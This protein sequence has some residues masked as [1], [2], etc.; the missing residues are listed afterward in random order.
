MQNEKTR[1]Q[2]SVTIDFSATGVAFIRLA[3]D[4]QEVVILN[5]QRLLELKAILEQFK[6]QQPKALVIIASGSDMFSVGADIK[7]IGKVTDP[8]D[9]A[10]LAR[11]GQEVF[12][13]I[14]ALS[15][16]TIAAISGPCVGG[17]CE[18]VLACKYRIITDRKSSIIGLPEIKL[19]I[20]PGFGG[21]QR[22]PRL[23]GLS[24]AADLILAGKLLKP[25]KAREAGLVD[26]VV[27]WE[28][29]RNR[30]E[31]I[32]LGRTKVKRS[33]GLKTQVLLSKL[34][35][36]RKIIAS[37]AESVVRA[38]TKGFYPAP[39]AAL[40]C[41]LFGYDNGMIAGLE[42]EAKQLGRLIAS[43]E[44]KALVNVFFLTE[45]AKSI[46][47][48]AAK[49][50]SNIKTMVIGAGVM[51]AGIATALA[52]AELPVV[53]RDTNKEALDRGL[54]HAKGILAKNKSLSEIQRNDILRKISTSQTYSEASNIGLVIEAVFEEMSVKQ[55]VFAEL[56]PH[57]SPDAL[58]ASNTSSLSISALAENIANPQRVVGMHFF[59]PVEKM[60]LVEIVRGQKTDD[61]TLVILAA[62]TS[63]LQKFPIIVEDVPGFLINRVLVPYLNE[64]A[65]LLQEGCSIED[66]D[67]SA[68]DFGLPMG[69]IRLLDEVGLDIAMHVQKSLSDAYG[70]RMFGPTFCQ[71]LVA[72][73]KKGRKNSSGFYL[74]KGKEELVDQSVYELLGLKRP[75]T[76][77]KDQ[78]KKIQSRLVHALLNEAIRC[79][80]EGVAGAPGR[81]AAQQ[82]DL[83]TVMGM[84]FPP[85]RGGVIFFADALGAAGVYRTL[86]ELEASCGKRF[87][88]TAGIRARAER[89]LSFY[90]T[91]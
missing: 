19:G 38:K 61:K 35:V 41:M 44:C 90:E 22:L 76:D 27:P 89:N 68:L 6:Q 26:Q 51:G 48:S 34:S 47:K 67:K 77:L 9:G 1:A 15:C 87:A 25:N 55:Q 29:L 23:I 33:F 11:T 49:T 17:G 31:E 75:A 36:V 59:N 60:P 65:F 83:G 63:K 84:G 7:V 88:P 56:A 16:P 69:P 91:I 82:I 28:L 58:V 10:K 42:N 57:L 86:V 46:G 79:L 14:A 64:A 81:Q 53:I 45:S 50:C 40:D 30:A 3:A 71:T 54:E 72:K 39:F 74:Y 62:I 85:F 73:G 13:L 8:A 70:E 78:Q 21:T 37:K 80:D 43:P 2:S 32:A 12:D 5:E 24:R 20:L 66:I 52:Q 4:E 18:L